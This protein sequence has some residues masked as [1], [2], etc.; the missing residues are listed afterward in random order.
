MCCVYCCA[1][2]VALRQAE[3]DA[4]G[5]AY[6]VVVELLCPVKAANVRHRR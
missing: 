5:A 2:A 3:W 4:E 1:E 6:L